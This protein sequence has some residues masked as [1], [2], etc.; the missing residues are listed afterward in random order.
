MKYNIFIQVTLK[1]LFT[2]HTNTRNMR[3]HNILL[4]ENDRHV[5]LMKNGT[6]SSTVYIQQLFR[7]RVGIFNNTKEQLH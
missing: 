5:G 7:I 6:V 2:Y 4:N 3:E 1:K